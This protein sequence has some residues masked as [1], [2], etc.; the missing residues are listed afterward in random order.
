MIAVLTLTFVVVF[1]FQMYQLQLIM[2]SLHEQDAIKGE[3]K[4]ELNVAMAS[5]SQ[6]LFSPGAPELIMTPLRGDDVQIDYGRT[7]DRK[8]NSMLMKFNNITSKKR[9]FSPNKLVQQSDS[10]MLEFDEARTPIV[11][12][13]YKLVLFT[14]PKVGSTV[15]GSFLSTYVH[16]IS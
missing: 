15:S 3:P 13:K 2:K 11:L 6:K 14:N 4:R 7:A 10:I 5:P 16:R 12:E 9:V 8:V 1:C